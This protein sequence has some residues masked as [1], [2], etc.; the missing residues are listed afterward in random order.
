MITKLIHEREEKR[1]ELAK[2][3]G[4]S[5]ASLYRAMKGEVV[6]IATKE[7]LEAFFHIPYK[8]EKKRDAHERIDAMAQ[9]F[10]AL[11]KKVET[12]EK[13][14]DNKEYELSERLRRLEKLVP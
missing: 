14:I 12:L 6:S 1:K 11:T 10:A 3:I 13:T 2:M 9:Y 7:K 8:Q 5:E 4:I